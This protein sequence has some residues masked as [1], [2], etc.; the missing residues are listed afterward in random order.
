MGVKEGK[1]YSV[2]CAY[3]RINGEVCCGSDA[4]LTKI[5]RDEW[6]FEGYIVSDCDAIVDIYKGHHVTQTPERSCG[7]CSQV[8][9]RSRMRQGV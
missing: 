8:G 1:A 4:L 6:G 5:L 7:A 3:N 2:M 9:L